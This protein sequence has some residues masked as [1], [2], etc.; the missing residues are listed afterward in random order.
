MAGFIKVY[1]QFLEWEW[2]SDLNV[3]V[4]FFHCLLRANFKDQKFQGQIIKRGEFVTSIAH[5]SAETGLSQQQT[6]T[7]LEKLE[8]TEEI[9]KRTTS[10]YTVITVNNWDKYQDDNKQI[11]NEQ[12]TNNK[13]I[14]TIEEGK[15]GKKERNNICPFSKDFLEWFALYPRKES[16]KKA[17]E[18]FN[19]VLKDGVT[20]QQLLDGV[21]DYNA[22][23]VAENI[24]RQYVKMPTTWLNQGCWEDTYNKPKA[25]SILDGI[26]R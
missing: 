24:D 16:K 4:L 13:R 2:Y 14:T 22:H 8:K 3:R 11:T 21:K 12:Q 1:R 15:E 18:C 23:I 6:R 25:K 7:A 17:Y 5:L 10:Q 19:R 20:M 26:V 9:N